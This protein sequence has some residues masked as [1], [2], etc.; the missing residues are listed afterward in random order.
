MG[1]AGWPVLSMVFFL[2]ACTT[3]G[4]PS[5]PVSTLPETVFQTA[6]P[7]GIP[8]EYIPPP[9]KCRVWYHDRAPD[10]QPAQ[11]RCLEIY[12]VP[13]G[14][15]LVYG[16]ARIKTYRIEEYDPQSPGVVNFIN[17]FELES[18]RFLRRVK[19]CP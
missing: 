11:E 12:D 14:A 3:S 18:G 13:A 7:V 10:E 6:V 5:V 4:V 9:G 8:R 1:K 19:V 16:G 2:T 17:Y 15:R